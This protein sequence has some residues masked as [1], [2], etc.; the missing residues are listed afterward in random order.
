MVYCK[1]DYLTLQE[2]TV[3][4]QYIL[5][6]LIS[7]GWTK[8][9]ICG[10]LG[11][12]QTES[13]INPCIWQNL[14]AGNE[15]LGFG[16]VQWTPSTK[17]SDWAES[18]GLPVANMDSELK[19][20]LYEV[21]NGIQ[22]ISTSEY[23]MT[24]KQFTLSTESPE[25]LADV[26][27]TNYERPADS[28]QPIRGEQARYWYDTLDGEGSGICVQL[29]QF[30][31]DI[32]QVTQGE[33]GSFSHQGTLAIDFVGTS[34]NYPYY[35]PCDCECVLR[36]DSEALLGF[37]SLEQVM[38]ADGVIRNIVW[39][40]VHDDVLNYNVGDVLEKGQLMGETGTGAFATG[41]HLHLE[42]WN[43]SDILN[44][45]EPLH[46]YNVFATNGVNI[47]DGG[48]YDWKTSDYIDCS[49]DGGGGD[50]KNNKLD[51]IHLL[52]CDALHGWK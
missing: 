8:N 34:L 29:A 19:R 49:N 7:R 45:L 48:G 24:F 2:M 1:N 31:M 6:Y 18:N 51:L 44:R 46:I 23:P 13:T 32:I 52:L 4:A 47:V 38:C 40:C 14:D 10:M 35:A 37:K 11:N 41:D 43:G 27:I 15:S 39:W 16:L 36:D 21:N 3:N 12:M 42:V 17:Y 25:Y 5:D 26:F 22:W 50:N 30:P 33:N 20:I 9:A 28:D